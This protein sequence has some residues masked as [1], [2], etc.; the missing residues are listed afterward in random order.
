MIHNSKKAL[1]DVRGTGPIAIF[2]LIDKYSECGPMSRVVASV[3]RVIFF[4]I[5]LNRDIHVNK[6]FKILI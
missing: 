5:N 3:A 2:K 4:N 1:A 6:A